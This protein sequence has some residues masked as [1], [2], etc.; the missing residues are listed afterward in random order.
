VKSRTDFGAFSLESVNTF[1]HLFFIDHFVCV[2]PLTPQQR[3][4]PARA[5]MSSFVL[6]KVWP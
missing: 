3:I 2:V 5:I 1:L 4:T 6:A